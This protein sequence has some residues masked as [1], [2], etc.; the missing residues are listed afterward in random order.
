[1][2]K[3]EKGET[4]AQVAILT[5][6]LFTLVFAVVHTCSLW[7]AAQTA[8]VAARRGAR[9]AS[10]AGPGIAPYENAD[11]AVRTTLRELGGRLDAPLRVD[12]SGSTVMVEVSVHFEGIVPF[13]PDR[14]V[15]AASLP[16]EQFVAE[17][18]R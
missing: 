9:A 12:V 7:I 1:M 16:L 13:L 11:I 6:L 10:T 4:S 14:V 3:V 18:E 15:R 8:Q 2:R 5:P 17:E